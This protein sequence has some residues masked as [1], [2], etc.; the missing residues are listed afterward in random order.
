MTYKVLKNALMEV[1]EYGIDRTGEAPGEGY[2]DAHRRLAPH[3]D[4]SA[5]LGID[6]PTGPSEPGHRKYVCQEDDYSLEV[7][8]IEAFALVLKIDKGDGAYTSSE[9]KATSN[10]DTDKAN[11]RAVL[12]IDMR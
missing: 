1:V 12:R 9:V 8:E 11:N 7:G 3:A 5:D 6:G 2:G 10:Y 4:S